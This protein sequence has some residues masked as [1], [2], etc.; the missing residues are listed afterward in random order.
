MAK[1]PIIVARALATGYRDGKKQTV[2]HSHLDFTLYAGELT[3]LLGCNGAGKSTLLR[4]LAGAQ[5][6]LGGEVQLMQ[7]PLAGYTA[8]ELSRTM[9]L[10]LTERTLTGGLTVFELVA[11]GRQ[12]HTGF[13]GRLT[14]HDR[15]VVERAVQAVGL[16]DKCACYVSELS[17]GERQKTMIAKALVQECPVILL[18]EPTAFLDVV[19]RIEI[20]ALLRRLAAD[21]HKAVLLSTHDVDQA[22]AMADVLWLMTPHGGMTC[23]SPEDL[24]LQAQL[25]RLFRHDGIRFDPARG[26]YAP[27]P[28]GGGEVLLRAADESLRFWASNAMCRA[29][30]RVVEQA[31]VPCAVLTVHSAQQ[32][33]WE[34]DGQV[35]TFASFAALLDSGVTKAGR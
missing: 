29:G 7:R 2:V 33:C 31:D 5:P 15:T 32:L 34:Y 18:D 10:V 11:L 9:G 24:A 19:S 20:M 27:V 13:F 14:V 35:Q 17:D 25:D 8:R 1:E 30:L 22:F 12:P 26:C 28:R 23:G 4:T 3:C 16:S 6:V 21:E